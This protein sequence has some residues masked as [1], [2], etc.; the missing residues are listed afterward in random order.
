MQSNE[1]L[2]GRLASKARPFEKRIDSVQVH[3]K[4]SPTKPPPVVSCSTTQRVP[5]PR[6]L[7]GS[8]SRSNQI[9]E[10]SFLVFS[11]RRRYVA[12]GSGWQFPCRSPPSGDA[13]Q[14][15]RGLAVRQRNG[16]SSP[17]PNDLL[18]RTSQDNDYSRG[19][20]ILDE[21][22]FQP[23]GGKSVRWIKMPYHEMKKTRL[24]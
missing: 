19:G 24:R 2:L 13:F 23:K 5:K 20:K 16:R 14:R 3:E 1:R 7:K 4:Q 10:E 17:R 21:L 8:T 22:L 6:K 9:F 15:C 12:R 18:G 11:T